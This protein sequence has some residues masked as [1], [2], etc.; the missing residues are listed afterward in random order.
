MLDVILD[1]LKDSIK[2][3]PFLFVTYLV[4]GILAACGQ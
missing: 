3:I 1:A 4:M 2:L